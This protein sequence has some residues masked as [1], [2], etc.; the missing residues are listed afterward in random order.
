LAV[1]RSDYSD[2]M[3]HTAARCNY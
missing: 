3:L 1:N 2:I